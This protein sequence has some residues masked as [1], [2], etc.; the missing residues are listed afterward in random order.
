MS[1]VNTSVLPPVLGVRYSGIL[2]R[3]TVCTTCTTQIHARHTEPERERDLSSLS[4]LRLSERRKI[5]LR[6]HDV[7]RFCRLSLS[8]S[9]TP[10]SAV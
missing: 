3:C 10:L 1:A 5:R 7:C 9:L 6:W 8:V 2:Y 4:L